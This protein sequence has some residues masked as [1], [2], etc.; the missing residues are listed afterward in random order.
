MRDIYAS[1]LDRVSPNNPVW[2]THST[3]HYGVANSYALNLANISGNTSN[4]PGVIIDRDEKGIPTGLLREQAAMK[5]ITN[6]IPPVTE[7]QLRKAIFNMIEGFYAEGMTALKDPGIDDHT[8]SV[9]RQLLD[10]GRL[11]VRV[12]PLWL[13]G[14]TIE[15]AQQLISQM[16]KTLESLGNDRL[17]TGG[18]KLY[19]DGSG[20]ARTAW[21]YDNWNK[22]NIDI[23]LAIKVV[24]KLTP[25]FTFKWRA[26][27]IKRVFMWPPILLGIAALTGL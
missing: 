11:T 24:L 12:F 17:L 10:E 22:T 9:Y 25:L 8:W 21:L 16:P 15:S 26:S 7:S 4:P 14:N 13:G 19:I 6:Q 23:D 1:D 3:G 20:G 27:F 2:L 18:V 5:M